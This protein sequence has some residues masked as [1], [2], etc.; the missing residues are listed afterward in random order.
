M[1]SLCDDCDHDDCAACPYDLDAFENEFGPEQ[2]DPD[3]KIFKPV[4]DE[5]N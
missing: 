1:K 2:L 4:D 3:L 5:E